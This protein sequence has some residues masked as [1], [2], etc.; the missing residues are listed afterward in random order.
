MERGE[1]ERVGVGKEGRVEG[2]ENRM[3]GERDGRIGRSGE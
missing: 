1:E 2:T 3:W